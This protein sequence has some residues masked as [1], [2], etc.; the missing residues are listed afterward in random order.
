[1]HFHQWEES[2]CETELDH[3]WRFT[4]RRPMTIL[5]TKMPTT[6]F[7]F[8]PR[9]EIHVGSGPDSLFAKLSPA[10]IKTNTPKY[11]SLFL[12]DSVHQRFC[13]F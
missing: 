3:V 13:L 2:G 4:S 9:L 1:M 10:A 11:P 5:W 8:W 7:V 12:L 6:A